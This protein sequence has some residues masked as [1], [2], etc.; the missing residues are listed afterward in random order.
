[1]AR[2]GAEEFL[3]FFAE[4]PLDKAQRAAERLRK[5]IEATQITVGGETVPITMTLGVADYAG[6]PDSLVG[7]KRADDALYLGKHHG[8]NRVVA[9][10]GLS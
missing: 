10:N 2:G 9:T 1:V 7:I 5:R 4:T 6:E 3:M 8:K